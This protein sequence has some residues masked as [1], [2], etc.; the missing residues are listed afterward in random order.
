MEKINK[1]SITGDLGSGKS[2]VSKILCAK[3]G[4][5]YMSTG[6]IQ[7]QLAASM[8]MDTLEMNRRA[9]VDPSIDQKIDGELKKLSESS[10]SYI[11]DSRLAWFFVPNSFKVYLKV[12]VAT[13]AK[14]IMTDEGRNSEEYSSLEEAEKKLEAR[15][16][17]ENQRFLDK[18]GADCSNMS[19]FDLILDT[20]LHDP[21]MVAALILKAKENKELGVAFPPSI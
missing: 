10:D 7:R 21:E 13:A 20:T 4:Y 14:R 8:G 3:T 6:Q 17:S 18:Y 2:A 19:N 11:I 1:I 15:K 5:K 9:D 12:D 16:G